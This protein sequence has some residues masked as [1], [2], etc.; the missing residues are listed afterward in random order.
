[1]KGL[2][3][4]F[5]GFFIIVSVCLGIF[6]Y[7]VSH[8][9]EAEMLLGNEKF[10]QVE[11]G[12]SISFKEYTVLVEALDT[13]VRSVEYLE[14]TKNES[15][16][17]TSSNFEEVVVNMRNQ[18]NKRPT[19]TLMIEM[20]Y[21]TEESMDVLDKRQLAL[22]TIFSLIPSDR[23]VIEPVEK[24]GLYEE[25]LTSKMGFDYAIVNAVE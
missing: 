14:V 10:N 8:S 6:Y 19:T 21:T 1:M 24:L 23:I 13:I 7:L 18:L 9:E 11:D 5:L 22:L 4:R 16:I 2:L 12:P 25:A 3:Y 15:T 17:Y 20:Y